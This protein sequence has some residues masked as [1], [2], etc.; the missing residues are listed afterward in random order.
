MDNSGAYLAASIIWYVSWPKY[1]HK[2]FLYLVIILA[3]DKHH[4][5]IKNADNI[6]VTVWLDEKLGQHVFGVYLEF[7][8]RKSNHH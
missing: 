5:T 7:N 8:Y 6:F 1:S 4:I 2:M 3:E